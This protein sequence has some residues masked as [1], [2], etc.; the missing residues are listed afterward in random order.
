MQGTL[1]ANTIQF[2][3]PVPPGFL[4]TT[5]EQAKHVVSVISKSTPSSPTP[6][7]TETNIASDAPSMIKAQVLAGGRG[8]GKFNSDGK[9]GVRLAHS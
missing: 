5:P 2:K 8:K 6:G 4:V 9:G 7:S 1:N 3:L